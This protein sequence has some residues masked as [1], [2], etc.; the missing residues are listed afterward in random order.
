MNNSHVQEGNPELRGNPLLPA[1][2]DHTDLAVA[3]DSGGVYNCICEAYG[4]GG[5][6][7]GWVGT[8]NVLST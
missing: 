5:G 2:T 4:K 7:H 3:R 6:M 8:D 1:H